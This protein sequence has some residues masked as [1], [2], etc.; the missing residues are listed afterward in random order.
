MLQASLAVEIRHLK[1]SRSPAIKLA[2]STVLQNIRMQLADNSVNAV[3][4]ALHQK[5]R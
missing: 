4:I 3:R 1:I 2:G 5:D